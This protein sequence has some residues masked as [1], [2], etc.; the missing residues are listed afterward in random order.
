M[1]IEPTGGFNEERET[2]GRMQRGPHSNPPSS[3]AER[4]LRTEAGELLAQNRAMPAS[5]VV[6]RVWLSLSSHA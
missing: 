1:T 4:E 2:A 3:A 5:F 6:S